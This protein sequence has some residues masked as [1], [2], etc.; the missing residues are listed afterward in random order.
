[1][2]VKIKIGNDTLTG[3][4]TVKFKNADNPSAFVAFSV[5]LPVLT[6]PTISMSGD[7]VSWSAVTNAK[8]YV[9]YANGDP[10]GSAV[11]KSFDAKVA[12]TDLNKPDGVYS[13]TV[14][15]F[16]DG[17]SYGSSGASNSVSYDFINTITDLMGTTW[18]VSTTYNSS[19]INPY[20]AYSLEG[21][22]KVG[23]STPHTVRSVA[24]V[25]PTNMSYRETGVSGDYKPSVYAKGSEY[26]F[27]YI[28]SN[29]SR[30]D[31]NSKTA[32]L[33]ITGGTDL[34]D[35]NLINWFNENF[36]RVS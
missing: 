33:T 20:K 32:T 5:N 1:M 11:K 10:I 26:N 36:T 3:V 6:A 29:D 27:W 22:I 30:S 14:R 34:K 13:L 4:N 25:S 12:M 21:S 24:I 23:T 28:S 17:I 8:Y 19:Y 16:G 15:A 31:M 7:T 2:S 9:V 18:M 35:T